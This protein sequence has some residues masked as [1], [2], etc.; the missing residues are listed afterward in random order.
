MISYRLCLSL[1]Y[2]NLGFPSS[3]DYFRLLGQFT[4][5]NQAKLLLLR[6]KV[7]IMCCFSAACSLL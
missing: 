6:L 2:A 7:K 1:F 3:T 5:N 4:A